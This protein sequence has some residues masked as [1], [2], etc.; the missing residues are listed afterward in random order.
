M[1]QSEINELKKQ[2]KLDNT[3]VDIISY[4]Y[5]DHEKNIINSDT[6]RLGVMSEEDGHKWL[7]LF[8]KSLGGKI[9]KNQI[10][11]PFANIDETSSDSAHSL[12]LKVRESGLQQGVLRDAL[13]RHII[14]NFTYAEN[15]LIAAMHNCYDIPVKGTDKLS[16]GESDEIYEYIAVAICPVKTEKAGL[17]FNESD[18]QI[19]S[20][21]QRFVVDA[22]ISGFLFPAFNDRSADVHEMLFYTKKTDDVHKELQAAFSSTKPSMSAKEQQDAFDD[23]LTGVIGDEPDFNVVKNIHESIAT[24][25]KEGKKEGDIPEFNRKELKQ[26]FKDAGV[27]DNNLQKFDA[28]YDKSDAK[29]GILA[30]NALDCEKFSVKMPDVEIKVKGDKT[31]LVK[32]KMIDGQKYIVITAENVEL[33]GVAVK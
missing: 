29:Q 24:A 23:I 31:H 19:T 26:I 28:V 2:L 8:K 32:E 10:E 5:V 25:V 33:N 20:K 11:I 14:D 27:P 17:C 6:Q 1:I 15:F 7:E 9:G 4:A 22:P 21:Q 13:F 16:M 18:G 12:L 3:S 30:I